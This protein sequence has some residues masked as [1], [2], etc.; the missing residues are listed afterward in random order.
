[1][2]LLITGTTGLVGKALIKYLIN[3]TEYQKKPK[4]VRILVRKKK[5]SPD[6]EAFIEWCIQIGID[7]FYGDL[8]CEES[9]Y[10]F[11][12]VNDPEDTTLIHSGAIFNFWQPYKL[13]YDVNV[14]GTER[15]LNGFHQNN[16]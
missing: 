11:T 5:N 13:L 12:C 8:T 6:R 7:I 14:L 10:A 4:T 9:V 16:L 2:T 3:E 15:I 1:M